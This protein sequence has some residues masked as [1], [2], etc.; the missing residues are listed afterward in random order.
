MTEL[1]IMMTALL[2]GME[3]KKR[4]ITIK[5]IKDLLDDIDKK[6]TEAEKIKQN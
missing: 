4:K 1:M 6:A 5:L 2:I 3:S